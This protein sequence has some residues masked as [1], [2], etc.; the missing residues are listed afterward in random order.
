M[1]YVWA[2]AAGRT[3]RRDRDPDFTP[4]TAHDHFTG[5]GT[6]FVA[7][8]RCSRLLADADFAR[9]VRLLDPTESA[10]DAALALVGAG[11]L[12]PFQ[13]QRLLA[14]K[15]DGLVLGQY[16][17]LDQLSRGRHERVYKARHRTMDRLVA[18]R[19]LAAEA[20]R[21][22]A[23][24]AAVQAETRAA[25]RLAHPNVMTVLDANEAGDRLFVVQEYVEAVPL[26]DLVAQTRRL[27]TARACEVARQAALGL[28]HAHE[29]GLPHGHFHPGCVV[30]GRPGAEGAAKPGRVEVKVSD[31]GTAPPA[32]ADPDPRPY[33][34]P[35]L[36][37]PR[38]RASVA[39]DLYSLGA[40]LFYLLTGRPP[41]GDAPS[42]RAVRPTLPPAVEE[43]LHS[44]LAP[45][46]SHRPVSAEEVAARL[47]AFAESDDAAP[48][49][50]FDLPAPAFGPPAP[51]SGGFLSAL[52]AA[53]DD[54]L[55]PRP[56]PS[57]DDTSPWYGIESEATVENLPT[58][59]IATAASP[60]R[61]R[62]VALALVC[63]VGTLLALATLVALAR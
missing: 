8:L 53:F 1:S 47:E 17:L 44:L 39:S 35:E 9:A 34:A 6:A 52:H 31:F 32:D 27:P 22:P 2:S 48:G 61:R 5:T 55:P 3:R 33:R 30:V 43:L 54:R 40:V 14:G 42:A 7:T 23:R 10:A 63:G 26:A 29:K 36:A 50:D 46:P 37:A 16:V 4:M 13:A 56:G 45:N 41:A 19:V 28:H 58:P 24:R 18:I 57:P 15:A 60:P 11:V 51:V 21:D 25:A 59:V 62:F 49:V 20:T 12:T 38:A